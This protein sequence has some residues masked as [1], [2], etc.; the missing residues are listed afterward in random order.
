MQMH[1]LGSGMLFFESPEKPDHAK[2]E[3]GDGKCGPDP[4]QRRAVHRQLRSKVR[5]LRPVLSQGHARIFCRWFL[6]HTTF[7]EL[8][9][10]LIGV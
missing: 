3:S 5:D 6:S 1:A 10:N 8:G 2:P 4:C 7:F 9:I